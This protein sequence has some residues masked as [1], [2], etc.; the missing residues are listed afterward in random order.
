MIKWL[1]GFVVVALIFALA[2]V[3]V[4]KNQDKLYDDDDF[5]DYGV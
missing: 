4:A 2:A 1:I 5:S 3:R